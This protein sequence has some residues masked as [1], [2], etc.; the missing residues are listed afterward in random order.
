MKNQKYI[1]SATALT[2][3][4]DKLGKK[5]DLLFLDIETTG[6]SPNTSVIYLIGCCY[7]RNSQ[8]ICE[9]FFATNP[10]E[11]C[12]I[13]TAFLDVMKKYPILIHFNGNQFD[14]PFIKKRCDALSIPCDFDKACG[15]DIYKRIFPYRFFL[16][17]SNCKQK[18]LESFLGINRDDKY[19][20]GELIAVYHEYCQSHDA[21]AL[22]LLLLHNHDDIEGML[23][24]LP[25]LTYT[26][27]FSEHIKV[28]KVQC[29]SYKDVNDVKKKELLLTLSFSISIPK[30]ISFQANDCYFSAKDNNGLLKIPVYQEELQYF[31]ENYHDYYYLPEEDMAVHKSVSTY[32][33][34]SFREQATKATCYTRKYSSYLPQWDHLFEPFFKREFKSTNLFFELTEELK[35]NR[36]AFSKYASHVLSMMVKER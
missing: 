36:D 16:K 5:E 31:Y 30:P 28:K 14:L 32:V 22:S 11:E 8:W 35:T 13:L 18:T 7:Y 12:E 1:I 29:N 21:E 3:P 27:L 4:I 20:G 34:H 15:I 33:D 25:V 9:Q 2:Y 24:L 19:Q 6:L 26:D 17:L 10:S 23:M